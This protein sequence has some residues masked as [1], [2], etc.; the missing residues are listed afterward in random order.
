MSEAVQS[1]T[2]HKGGGFNLQPRDMGQAM[3]MAKML[4]SSGM[5]PKQYTGKPQDTLVAMMMGSE[6]GLNP[7]QSLQN[8]AVVNGRPSIYGDALVALVQNH[9]AFG[10]MEESFDEQSMT[11]KCT[12]WRKGGTPHT[13]TFS[14]A[15]AE[16]AGL[17]GKQGPWQNYPKR[18]LQM[19][20]RGFALRDRFGDALAGLIT[21]E[22]AH[23]MP[24]SEVDVTPQ[25]REQP[26]TALPCYPEDRFEEN[27]PAWRQAIE[28]GKRTPDQI[29]SMIR[30]KGTLTEDQEQQ[31]RD[32][33]Q[34]QEEPAQ[35]NQS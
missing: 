20:A 8:I 27:L 13:Q 23:D 22:E 15:D 31:I 26:R 1:I 4:S 2:K 3:E 14:K 30:S 21:A 6:L 17:W 34:Q 11:A 5:V 16:K 35:E 10:G 18:M 25:Q 19:R 32:I 24:Q 33:D 12:V 29:I 28:S 7:I 9:P